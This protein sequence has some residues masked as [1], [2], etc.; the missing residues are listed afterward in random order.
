MSGEKD[1]SLFEA[2]K[3]VPKMCSCAKAIASLPIPVGFNR[4]LLCCITTSTDFNVSFVGETGS[5]EREANG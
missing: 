3:S 2:M 5:L 1:V 4:L